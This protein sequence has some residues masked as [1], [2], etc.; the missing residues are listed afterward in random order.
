MK[1]VVQQDVADRVG[2]QLDEWM[3]APPIPLHHDSPF[4]L[5]V[6]VV[7]SAQCTDARV[8]QVTP[9]LFARA[10]D[11]ASMARLSPAK[12]LPLIASCGLAPTKAKH[13]GELARIL[14]RECDGVVPA[15][16]ARLLALPGVG[17]KTANVV[18]SQAFGVPAFGVDTHV[19]R[20]AARWGLSRGTSALSVERDLCAL[21]PTDAWNR[22]HLQMIYFGRAFC[23][24]RGHDPIACPICKWVT[25]RSCRS[26]ATEAGPRRHQR[27]KVAN[28]RR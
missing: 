13:L 26:K 15:D 7:L 18:M 22:R 16:H 14:M 21:F 27:A 3:P 10:P 9:A 4:Q 20:L 19:M 5:L 23:P 25:S 17:R 6:A 2:Q 28:E 11:A 1:R 24:A 12:L 8:N